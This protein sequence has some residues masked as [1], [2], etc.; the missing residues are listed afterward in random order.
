MVN[1][2]MRKTNARLWR[3]GEK[4]EGSDRVLA[5]IRLKEKKER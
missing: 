1:A 2:E 3:G 4:K 5:L